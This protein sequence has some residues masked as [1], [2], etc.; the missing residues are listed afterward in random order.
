MG[1]GSCPPAPHGL[2]GGLALMLLCR[3]GWSW[4]LGARNSP[5]RPHNRL[6]RE[7]GTVSS[8]LKLVEAR[9]GWEVDAPPALEH[10]HLLQ[11]IA[12]SKASAL[13][14]QW[15]DE[16]ES[17]EMDAGCWRKKGW[18]TA[19]PTSQSKRRPMLLL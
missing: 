13:P 10:A 8:A 1:V 12:G 15:Q 19:A 16:L 14:A 18:I 4:S 6:W 2:A 3:R 9:S 11:V 17:W 5:S 7:M